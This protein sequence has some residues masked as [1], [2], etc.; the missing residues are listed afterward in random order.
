MAKV[1]VAHLAL[2]KNQVPIQS[3]SNYAFGIFGHKPAMNGPLHKPPAME[4][5]CN[6]SML[7]HRSKV[8]LDT[9]QSVFSYLQ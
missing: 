9:L 1:A 7:L 5:T 8:S 6:C 4:E 3:P 2:K